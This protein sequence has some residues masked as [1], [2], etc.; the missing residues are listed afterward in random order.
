MPTRR[1]LP[2]SKIVAIGSIAFILLVVAGLIW[3]AQGHPIPVLQPKGEIGTKERQLIYF[4]LGLSLIVV[5]PVF[6]MLF[7]FAWK[8]RASNTKASYHPNWD[9]SNGFEALWWT[10]PTL[11]IIVLSVVTWRSSHEL[12]PYKPIQSNQQA[13]KVQVVALQWKWLF[14]YPDQGIATVNYMPVPTNRPLDLTITSDAPMNAFW[15]PQLGGQVYAMSGMSMKLQLIANHD[16]VYEGR[17]S[18]ISGKGFADMTFSVNAMSSDS[19]TSWSS[20]AK[21]RGASLS[22]SAYNSLAK[23]ATSKLFT[24]G[25]VQPNLYDTIIGKYMGDMNMSTTSN[26][27]H[28]DRPTAHDHEMEMQ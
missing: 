19:F 21:G 8:Y 15:V 6:A 5:L 3:Y 17:S 28:V 4:A 24:Y 11:L 23:P 1:R 13:L 16:G 14:I 27:Y 2:L 18:N 9:R 26:P 10:V 20:Y 12:D 7:T 22:Q 25:T